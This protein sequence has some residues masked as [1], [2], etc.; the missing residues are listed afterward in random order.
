MRQTGVNNGGIGIQ[1][2]F[3]TLPCAVNDAVEL[4]NQLVFELQSKPTAVE[5][6]V[7]VSTMAAPG[8]GPS[9]GSGSNGN[10]GNSTPGWV[11]GAVAGG[12]VALFIFAGVMYYIDKKR[13]ESIESNES[14][15]NTVM[16][17]LNSERAEV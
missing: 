13:N 4:Q 2:S 3:T 17:A 12:A 14:N 16:V 9:G 11:W 7:G 8:E 6:A 15:M 5:Q 10:G 1:F